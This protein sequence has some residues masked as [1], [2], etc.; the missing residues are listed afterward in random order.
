VGPSRF[1]TVLIPFQYAI[2]NKSPFDTPE[3]RVQR[4]TFTARPRYRLSRP[5]RMEPDTL[6]FLQT[7]PDIV[8]LACERWQQL[9]P[10]RNFLRIA[11]RR[12][13]GVVARVRARERS[14]DARGTSHVLFPFLLLLPRFGCRRESRRHLFTS[15]WSNA[16]GQ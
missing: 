16:S 12:G 13:A 6:V 9:K 10:R 11:V 2:N 3:T 4:V 7:W 15:P 1:I 8:A 5:R 14:L